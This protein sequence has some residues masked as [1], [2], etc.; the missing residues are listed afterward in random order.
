MAPG[1]ATQGQPKKSTNPPR[2]L[3]LRL[4]LV[5]AFLVVS[6]L[7]AVTGVGGLL[8]VKQIGSA[9]ESVAEVSSPLVN[10]A[11]DLVARVQDIS[12]SLSDALTLQSS[13]GIESAKSDL[14]E[15][16]PKVV[17]TFDRIDR[18]ITA[19]HVGIDIAAARAQGGKF[20]TQ[21]SEVV[22]AL[23]QQFEHA[24]QAKQ[25]F[26]EVNEELSAIDGLARTLAKQGETAIQQQNAAPAGLSRTFSVAREIY[27]LQ[28]E[29]IDLRDAARRFLTERDPQKLDGLKIGF[30]KI[31]KSA[32][33]RAKQLLARASGDVKATAMDIRGKLRYIQSITIADSGLFGL[34]TA[35]LGSELTARAAN[36]RLRT[37]FSEL[38]TSL[39][40]VSSM[41]N[42]INADAV[43]ATQ[44]DVA[45]AT[46]S[47]GGII[48]AGIAVSLIVGLLMARGLSLPLVRMTEAMTSLADGNIDVRIPAV[49][50]RDEIGSMAAAVQVFKENAEKVEQMTTDLQA[51]EHEAQRQVARTEKAA[52]VFGEVFAAIASGDFR[53][54]VEGEFDGSFARLKD[55]ANAMAARLERMTEE[56][57]DQIDRTSL[58]VVR[59]GGMFEAMAGGDLKHRMEGEFDPSFAMLKAD[60]NS[61]ADRLSETVVQANT[62]SANISAAVTQVASGGQNLSERTEQQASTLEETAASMEELTSTV[63]QNADNAQQANQVAAKARDVAVEGGGIVTETATA[64]REIE[65]SSQKIA[66]ITGMINDIAFQ[67]NLL[68]LNASVEAARA[69]DAGKGFAVVAS[70]VRNLAQRAADSSKAIQALIADSGSHVQ[71]GVDLV[72]RSG[73]TLEEIMTAIKKTADIVAEIS[74]ASNEQ[75]QSLDEVNTAMTQLDDMT[76]RNA[77]MVQEFAS[78]ARS[79]EEEVNRLVTLMAFFDT[80][81]D[82]HG[83]VSSDN[84][85]GDIVSG[86]EDRLEPRSDAGGKTTAR[87]LGMT[88]NHVFSLWSNVNDALI[89]AAADPDG[90]EFGREVASMQPDPFSQKAPSDVL[91]QV[92]VFRGKLDRL[93]AAAGLGATKI[94][95]TEDGVVEP[96][97]VFLNSGHV[98]NGLVDWLGRVSERGCD[99]NRF[100]QRG[101]CSGKTPSDVFGMVDLANRRADLILA[102]R[103]DLK[104][105][106]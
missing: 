6:L 96:S 87:N 7:V 22:G 56:A 86:A 31:L 73:E 47:T 78:A 62:V 35:A 74:A 89:E 39:G 11:G 80:G 49:G 90:A 57:Q 71:K 18:L 43:A 106:V 4:R 1:H 65:E 59:F 77:A 25:Q 61:M 69:G 40:A 2:R 32:D 3:G 58:A 34:H 10:E 33:A 99:E 103:G 30:E 53:R 104:V 12:L 52:D 84:P 81:Q 8:F 91:E 27:R 63:R 82:R 64:M 98:L 60:T 55:D 50:R 13:E 17:E 68:A 97:D 16:K 88:S 46:L 66:D 20:L 37:S 45:T 70:E 51:R 92:V 75:S 14:E 79:M 5:I 15:Q 94:Y 23:A 72:R 41:A 54:R 42:R 36:E 21:A 44:R 101:T 28:V 76:Q 48:L 102:R 29:V 67:T 19:G 24:E 83:A 105:A 26:E 9:V 93:R 38:R 100:Y 85:V 95:G